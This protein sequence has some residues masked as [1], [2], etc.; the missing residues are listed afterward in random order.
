[1]VHWMFGHLGSLLSRTP[2]SQQQVQEPINSS[3]FQSSSRIFVG[4]EVELPRTE[5]S[6]GKVS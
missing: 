5:E 2:E 6:I 4:D 3:L 1:M